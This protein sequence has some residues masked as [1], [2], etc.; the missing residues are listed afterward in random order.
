MRNET[1]AQMLRIL[2]LASILATIMGCGDANTPV[3]PLLRRVSSENEADR[4]AAENLKLLA[5]AMNIYANE[6]DTR[7][8]VA[9][10][11]SLS[12]GILSKV[13][14]LD[15]VKNPVTSPDVLA[16]L[17]VYED[18]EVRQAVAE[19]LKTPSEVLSG[20]S[21]TDDFYVRRRVARN[22]RTPVAVLTRLAGD[23]DRVVRWAVAGNPNT[24][25][26]LLTGMAEDRDDA[27]RFAVANNPDAPAEIL[28]RLAVD[29][30]ADVRLAAAENLKKREPK[31]DVKPPE[32]PAEGPKG[33]PKEK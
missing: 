22:P 1:E 4:L 6:N 17:A 11:N 25:K 18:S 5:A 23:Q 9:N 13:N 20:M 26:D 12:L 10:V 31:P 19:N 28:T 32:K 3:D 14:C 30:D 2:F 8:P 27:L 21:S 7:L 24:P 15:L 29:K 16:E 33:P